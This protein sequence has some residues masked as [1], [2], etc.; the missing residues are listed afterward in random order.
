MDESKETKSRLRRVVSYTGGL[1][2]CAGNWLW[3]HKGPMVC[4]TTGAALATAG[5]ILLLPR[6]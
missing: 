5:H 3:R 1:T 4:I 2:R 6:K